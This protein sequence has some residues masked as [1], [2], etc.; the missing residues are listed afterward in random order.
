MSHFLET[1]KQGMQD[2]QSRF[3]AA[4]QR[5]AATQAEFQAMQQ[6]LAKDQTDF[7]SALQEFQA[8]QTLVNLQTRK[9][10]PQAPSPVAAPS[11]T[12]AVPVALSNGSPR[13]PVLHNAQFLLGRLAA[14]QPPK[15]EGRPEINKTEAVRELLRQHP[16]GMTPGDIW[17]SLEQEL[18]NR[19]YLYSV[20]KRLK[21]KGDAKERRGKY[22]LISKQE[23]PPSVVQ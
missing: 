1:L 4:Q 6:R 9:E 23:A 11:V 5:L 8:F 7:Q 3:A 14:A 2:A 22:F 16:A 13:P 20:L 10:Q 19:T 17:K 15:D 21:D 12:V 18:S